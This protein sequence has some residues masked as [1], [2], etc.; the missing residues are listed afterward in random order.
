[1]AFQQSVALRNAALNA[2][3]ATIGPSPVLKLFS[4][5]EPANTAAADPPGP[6]ATIALPASAFAAASGGSMTKAGVW[7][8][9]GSVSGTAATFRIY[10]TTATTCH[11]QGA[12]PTDMTLD[13]V[14]NTVGSGQAITVNTFTVTKG[15]A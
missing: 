6:L 4:G 12:I 8:G 9:T 14:G 3:A 11:Y 2:E 5:A 1:M 10:E 15:N 7:A 13:S